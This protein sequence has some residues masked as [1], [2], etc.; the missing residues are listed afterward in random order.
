MSAP[1][2]FCTFRLGSIFLGV[3]VF[4]VQEVLRAQPMTRVP[5]APTAV[6]GLMNLR[7]QIVTALNLR[8]CLLLP[9]SDKDCQMN[10]VVRTSGGPVSFL[11]DEIGDVVVADEQFY[12]PPPETLVG[13]SR[14]LIK[15][16]L[17][18]DNE[19]LLILNTEAILQVAA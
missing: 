2:S 3:E 11:V 14:E 10:V 7:G 1:L 6:S 19:L 16:S 5:S 15:G 9:P 8:S 12:E 18:L 13:I 17:K 4:A